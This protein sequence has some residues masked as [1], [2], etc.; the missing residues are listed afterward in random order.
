MR[1]MPFLKKILPLLLIC[2]LNI[3]KINASYINGEDDAIQQRNEL[4]QSMRDKILKV[5]QMNKQQ[6]IEL[7]NEFLHYLDIYDILSDEDDQLVLDYTK[8]GLHISDEGYKVITKELKKY[9]DKE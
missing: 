8:E 1:M 4:V 9:I 3:P 7:S 6:L 2:C 5:P